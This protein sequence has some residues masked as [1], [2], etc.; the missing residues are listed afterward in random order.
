MSE[1]H[2]VS[3][4][5]SLDLYRENQRLAA[6]LYAAQEALSAAAL[7]LQYAGTDLHSAANYVARVHD[8]RANAWPIAMDARAAKQARRRAEQ[9]ATRA[10]AAWYAVGR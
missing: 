1:P 10:H 8:D 6:E 4:P 5:T 2:K 3:A 9:A 7:R